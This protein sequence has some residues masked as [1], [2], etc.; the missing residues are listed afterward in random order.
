MMLLL[1]VHGHSIAYTGVIAVVTATNIPLLVVKA[2]QEATEMQSA[3]GKCKARRTWV[4]W[5]R[6]RLCS[7]AILK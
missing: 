4:H 7:Q 3:T 5:P 1:A 6:I 2:T